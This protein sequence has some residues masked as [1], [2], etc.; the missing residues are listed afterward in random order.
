MNRPVWLLKTGLRTSVY[1]A[2]DDPAIESQRRDW[3]A[4]TVEVKVELEHQLGTVSLVALE[5]GGED[6]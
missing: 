2:D 3:A 5:D 6:S 4:R 1:K